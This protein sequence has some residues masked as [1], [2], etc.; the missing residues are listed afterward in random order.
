[1]AEK[2]KRVALATLNIGSG[3][4]FSMDSAEIAFQKRSIQTFP[5]AISNP[6]TALASWR[7]S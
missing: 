7:Q 3:N 2:E 1:M 5:L 6:L 4:R